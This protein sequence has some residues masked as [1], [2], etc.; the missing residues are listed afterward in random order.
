[1]RV[2]V[3][4]LDAL[5]VDHDLASARLRVYA[6]CDRKIASDEHQAGERR[7]RSK[8]IP[9]RLHESPSRWCGLYYQAASSSCENRTRRISLVLTFPVASFS[10]SMSCCVSGSPAGTTM[11]PP[12]LSWCKSGGGM[13][14]GAAVTMI[15]S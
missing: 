12:F 5:A 10:T 15:L 7:R 6:G 8:K 9:A 11:R 2:N 1:M 3:Y 14:S 13:R 4:G